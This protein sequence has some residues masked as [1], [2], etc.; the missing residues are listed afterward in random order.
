MDS[1]S[2]EEAD[3]RV[4]VH[5]MYALSCGA[6][7]IQVRTV[8]TDVIVILVGVFCEVLATHPLAEIWEGFGMGK[9]YKFHHICA[10]LGEHE[11]KAPPVFHSFTGCDTTSAFTGKGKKKRPG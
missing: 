7:K 6:N 9:T 1:C 2:H 5:M 3:T 4:V 8:V 11:S 10:S